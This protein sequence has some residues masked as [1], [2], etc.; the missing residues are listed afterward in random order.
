MPYC[1]GIGHPGWPVPARGR[2]VAPPLAYTSV[3]TIA[4]ESGCPRL[5]RLLQAL[6]IHKV[7]PS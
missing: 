4:C 5:A 7:T 1:D 3:I 2:G 6:V